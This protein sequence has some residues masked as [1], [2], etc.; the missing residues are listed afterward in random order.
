MEVA[1]GVGPRSHHAPHQISFVGKISVRHREAALGAD[2]ILRCISQDIH[3]ELVAGD[4]NRWRRKRGDLN[5]AGEEGLQQG[6]GSAN[7]NSRY[8]FGGIEAARR[9]EAGSRPDVGCRFGR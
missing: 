6:G 4:D 7:D 5:R 2:K 1:V 3:L 8:V 9:Q